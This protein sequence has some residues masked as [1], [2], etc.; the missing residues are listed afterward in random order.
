MLG[1][2][3]RRRLLLEQLM[4][5]GQRSQGIHAQVPIANGGKARMNRMTG[6]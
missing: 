3:G 6:E 4:D 2:Q 1:D 5:A